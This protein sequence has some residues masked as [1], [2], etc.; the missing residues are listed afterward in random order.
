MTTARETAIACYDLCSW[1]DGDGDDG[2]G[3][4]CLRCD[5]HGMIALDDFDDEDWE[6]DET[7]ADDGALASALGVDEAQ[8]MNTTPKTPGAHN[9]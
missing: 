4:L 5:G 1:C 2:C 8:R 6:G 9:A 3:W 7:P